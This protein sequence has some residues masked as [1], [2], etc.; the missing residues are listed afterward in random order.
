MTVLAAEGISLDLARRTVLQGA[1]LAAHSGRLTALI[2]P[3]GA[4][5]S[6]MLRVLAG[7][8]VPERGAVTF[9][10]A[11]FAALPPDERARS[12]AYL[13]QERTVHWPMSARAIVALGRLPHLG[14]GRRSGLADEA[15][16]SSAMAA[17]DVTQFAERPVLELSGGERARVLLA[18]ALAQ[19]PRVL[20]ADE[21]TAGLDPA[22]QLALLTHLRAAA[23]SGMAVIVALHDLA[24]A[25]RFADEV[26]LM[27]AGRTIAAG[28]PRD[29]LTDAV[30]GAAYGIQFL[31]IEHDGRRIVVPGDMMAPPSP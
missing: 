21:P 29:I 14:V 7:L 6:T 23:G 9:A 15:A 22:H 30:A 10:G 12:I 2:G 27:R 25:A 18:R 28:S 13:A 19:Q 5:K 1:S 20:I 8:L 26:V 11:P 3:N 17:M 16:I 4:G 31:S 24:L